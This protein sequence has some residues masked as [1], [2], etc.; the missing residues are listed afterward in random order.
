MHLEDAL[1]RV[2]ATDFVPGFVALLRS[3]QKSVI[4][5]RFRE[6][7]RS[8]SCP[9]RLAERDRNPDLAAI[10]L[11]LVAKSAVAIDELRLFYAAISRASQDLIITA[12]DREE[13]QPS[14][15]FDL[16]YEF[17]NPDLEV[18]AKRN[19]NKAGNL[20]STAN[21]VS[22]LRRELFTNGS[23]D[24]AATL[25]ALANAGIAG[26]DPSD[27]YGV[28][29]ISSDAPA[30]PEDE[31]VRVSPSGVEK[32]DECQLRWFLEFP[33]G[34]ADIGSSPSILNSE[35]PNI[36]VSFCWGCTA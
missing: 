18:E 8:D 22:K 21:V 29:P 27:W 9:P 14:T 35:I 25:K 2:R 7:A 4:G 12:V 6:P 36:P 3:T 26:A 24:A 28:K 16:A 11:E 5:N 1:N 23:T 15:Y 10:E 17:C 13:D 34:I 30:I 31:D 20:L 32:F 33:S 19:I